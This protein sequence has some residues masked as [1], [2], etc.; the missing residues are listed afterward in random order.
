VVS[1]SLASCRPVAAL[2][3]AAV[4]S[5]QPELDERTS[6]LSEPRILA[7]RA[8]P[9]EAAPGVSVRLD[10][11]V[12]D[13]AGAPVDAAI[14]WAFCT[15]RKPLA[16]LGPVSPR[17]LARQ[18]AAFVP[19][20]TGQSTPAVI[21]LDAC[22]LFGPDVPPPRPNEPPGRPVD[23]DET[24]GFYQPVRLLVPLGAAELTALERTRIACGLASAS[25]ETLAEFRRRYQPNANPKIDSVS[26][27]RSGAPE[28][29]EL[30]GAP[31]RVRTGERVLLR[32]GW[33]GCGAPACSGRE[34]YVAYDPARAAVVDRVESF[35]VS[36]FSAEGAFESDRTVPSEVDRDAA[37]NVW[38]TPPPAGAARVVVV[39]R[40]DRGGVG[41]ASLRFD[42]ERPDP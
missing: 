14:S 37:E 13:Q 5:C 20:G 3:L 21:P 29:L 17:C 10:A 33:P 32:A 23:P 35:V 6:R 7:V 40:D 42:V 22:R 39:V 9:A 24:G 8:E 41:W 25:A 18:G 1:R 15:E 36:G 4:P 27:V 16:E 34:P 11:L 19:F 31:H 30:D 2:L 12:V 38:T 26:V 28:R